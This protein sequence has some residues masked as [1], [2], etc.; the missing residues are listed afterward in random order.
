M[1]K[2]TRLSSMIPGVHCAVE[3]DGKVRN[4]VV[5]TNEKGEKFI[6]WNGKVLHEK[7]L[8]FGEEIE[9]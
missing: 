4:Y 5:Q 6:R 3:F 2:I 9:V 7:D 1:S 8:P